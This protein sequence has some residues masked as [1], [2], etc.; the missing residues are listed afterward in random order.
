MSILHSWEIDEHEWDKT[1]KHVGIDSSSDED[2]RPAEPSPEEAGACL[3]EMLIKLKLSGRLYANEACTLAYW[4]KYAGAIGPVDK[5]MFHPGAE[6]TGHYNRHFESVV[7]NKKT[8]ICMY[9][10]FRATRN[11]TVQG[12]YTTC[13]CYRRTRRSTHKFWRTQN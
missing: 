7:Q 1:P 11:M 13:L 6:S 8:K 10:G 9:L 3:A 2:D 12:L 4:A 5:L